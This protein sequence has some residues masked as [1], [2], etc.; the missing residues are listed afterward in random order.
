MHLAFLFAVFE[1]VTP[2]RTLHMATLVSLNSGLFSEVFLAVGAQQKS[3]PTKAL[4]R[5][6]NVVECPSPSPKNRDKLFQSIMLS[7]AHCNIVSAYS[8]YR[9]RLKWMFAQQQ[10]SR[11]ATDGRRS[12][13]LALALALTL[14]LDCPHLL[15]RRVRGSAFL[16]LFIVSIY[17]LYLPIP[18]PLARGL[19]S[20]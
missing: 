13:L 15:P 4:A 18:Y 20:L 9:T 11:T 8:S 16:S 3:S 12:A 19:S 5:W 7:S 1:V 10:T 14:S 17:K 2:Y 6:P